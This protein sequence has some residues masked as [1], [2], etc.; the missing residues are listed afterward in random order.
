MPLLSPFLVS[1]RKHGGLCFHKENM[2][3]KKDSEQVGMTIQTSPAPYGAW[4]SGNDIV[5]CGY[6]LNFK[7]I[8]N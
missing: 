6:K 7:T 3:T 5:R 1:T 8:L 4:A 2:G